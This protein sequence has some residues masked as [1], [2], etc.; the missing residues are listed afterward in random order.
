[1][2]RRMWLVDGPRGLSYISSHP[3]YPDRQL[4]LFKLRAGLQ[5]TGKIH[6]VLHGLGP[7]R[8]LDTLAILHLDLLRTGAA[9]RAQK[10]SRYENAE[11]GSGVPRFYLFERYGF[12]LEPLAV[13]ASV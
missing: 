5:Y 2:L 7:G 8:D 13:D 6:E 4:R 12:T 3:H 10:V 9:A 1:M 11:P